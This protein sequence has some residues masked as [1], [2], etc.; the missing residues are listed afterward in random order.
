MAVQVAAKPVPTF[1]EPPLLG[2]MRAFQK[3]RLTLLLRV[4]Q[5]CGPVARIHFGPFP[6]LVLSA[7][8]LIQAALVD[9]AADFDKGLA[10]HRAF[11]PVVGQGLINNE[12]ESWRH[13]RKLMAP[14]FTA[15]HIAGYAD[16]MVA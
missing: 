6:M 12:G 10:L 2:S 5:A 13:Q 7:P 8:D 4:T 3:D 11:T 1:P 9:H 16:T 15:R 14:A